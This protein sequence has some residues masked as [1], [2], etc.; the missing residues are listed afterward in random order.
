GVIGYDL[1]GMAGLVL[2]M[3]NPDIDAFLSMDSAILFGHFSGLPV[4]HPQYLE[5]R[6][7]I[8]WMHMTQARFIQKFHDE[9]GLSTLIGRKSYGDSYLVP[10]QTSNHGHFTSYAML[11]IRDAVPG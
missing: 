10:V 4:N 11:D 9:Q 1:G 7:T 5:K 3:R 2:S 8:P 6:F